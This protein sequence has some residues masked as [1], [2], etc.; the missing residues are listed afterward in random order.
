MYLSYYNLSKMPFSISPD[1][2]LLWLG[3]KHSEALATLKYGVYVLR[4]D[5]VVI[6]NE[7]NLFPD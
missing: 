3:E 4:V 5:S 1:A 6:S 2:S 7:R